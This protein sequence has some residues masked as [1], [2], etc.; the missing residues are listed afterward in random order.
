MNVT[1]ETQ[2]VVKVVI[3]RDRKGVVPIARIPIA[4]NRWGGYSTSKS[5]LILDDR[6]FIEMPQA[7]DIS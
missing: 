2:Q 1:N 3:R 5:A 4:C 7:R 6:S